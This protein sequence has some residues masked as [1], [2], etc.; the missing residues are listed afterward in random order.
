MPLGSINSSIQKRIEGPEIEP[1]FSHE[2]FFDLASSLE[3]YES[4]IFPEIAQVVVDEQHIINRSEAPRRRASTKPLGHKSRK[5][6]VLTQQLNSTSLAAENKF[7]REISNDKDRRK[8]TSKLQE[9]ASTLKIS[10]SALSA[11]PIH[12]N[13]SISSLTQGEVPDIDLLES[14]QYTESRG[15]FMD[16]SARRLPQF[17]TEVFPKEPIQIKLRLF[18]LMKTLQLTSQQEYIVIA[19]LAERMS[20]IDQKIQLSF[21]DTDF[22]KLESNVKQYRK[23]F[24]VYTEEDGNM[25]YEDLRISCYRLEVRN[26]KLGRLQKC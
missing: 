24:T 2:K 3:G 17:H 4:S 8:D 25:T 23:L 21:Y 15:T 14:M 20:L 9:L 1:Q 19:S 12:Q 7:E 5:N 11:Q 10:E 6:S 22:K 18:L 26:N 13:D 16:A